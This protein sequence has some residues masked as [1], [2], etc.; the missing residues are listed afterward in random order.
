MNKFHGKLVAGLATAALFGAL[1]SAQAQ[2]QGTAPAPAYAPAYAPP[3]AAAPPAA[4][5]DMSGQLGIGVGVGSG[6]D[7][8]TTRDAE[9]NIKYWLSDT[10]S[11]M[12]Q[13]ALGVFTASGL[14]TGYQFAPA[15]LVLYCPWKTTSTRLSVGGGLGLD[16]EKR[17]VTNA[18]TGVTAMPSN[19]TIGITLPIY[20]GVEHFFTKW[21]SMG[22]AVQNNFLSYTK[23]GSAHSFDFG[24]DTTATTKAVGFLFF[25]TD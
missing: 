20:A 4:A 9:I 8:V 3:P 21:F 15:A 5:S 22:V 13:F 17:S 11:V 19:A 10:L 7:L 1:G 2:D 14:S 23:F 24:L 6:T 12:P 16:F 25:Y 18:T